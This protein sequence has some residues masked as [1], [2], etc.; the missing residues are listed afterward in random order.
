MVIA[1]IFLVSILEL[2]NSILITPIGRIFTALVLF[3]NVFATFRWAPYSYAFINPVAGM[4]EQRN[5]DLDY[6]GLSSREGIDRLKKIDSSKSVFVMPDHSSSI[7]FGGQPVTELSSIA[8]PF[9]L[10]VFI[11]WNHKIVEDFCKI[12]FEIKRDNQ[13]LGVGGV[14]PR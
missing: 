10:Y 7:L 6:W 11:H 12:E 4:S 14:C 1:V 3:L 8:S 2:P 13:I 5:W 9:S